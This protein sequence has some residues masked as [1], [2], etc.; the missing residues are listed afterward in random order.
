MEMRRVIGSR[1]NYLEKV[2]SRLIRGREKSFLG[3]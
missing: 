3:N 2:C 1:H